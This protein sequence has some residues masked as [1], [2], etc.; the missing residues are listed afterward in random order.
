MKVRIPDPLRSY[1]GQRQTVEATGDT[2]G[3]VLDDLERQFPGIRF[4]MVDEQNNVRKH[5][6]VFVNDD[7]VRDLGISLRPGDELTIMQALSGG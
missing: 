2:V 5:M 3:A 4:R 1:T 7:A 6:K